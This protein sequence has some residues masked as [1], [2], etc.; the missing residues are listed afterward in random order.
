MFFVYLFLFLFVCLFVCFFLGGVIIFR[1][2]SD[3]P[4]G[5]LTTFLCKHFSGLKTNICVLEYHRLPA[6]SSVSSAIIVTSAVDMASNVDFQSLEGFNNDK[7]YV[8]RHF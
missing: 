3:Y 4:P 7:I 1:V 2:S 5:C 8:S 6:S